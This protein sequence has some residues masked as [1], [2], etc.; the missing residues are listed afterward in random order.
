MGLSLT[1]ENMQISS[2]IYLTNRRTYIC[3]V[4]NTLSQYMVEP[5]HVHL[6]AK[7]M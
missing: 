6:I 2:L 4:V 3:F 1:K 5:R 7:N